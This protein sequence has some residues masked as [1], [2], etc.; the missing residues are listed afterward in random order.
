MRASE[1]NPNP[2]LSSLLFCVLCGSWT[3]ASRI[4]KSP[5]LTKKSS[6]GRFMTGRT[7]RSPT[8]VMVVFFP[9]FFKQYLTVGRL[10]SCSTF[11]LGMA[12]GIASFVLAIMAPW[13]GALGDRGQRSSA[14]CSQCSQCSASSR[15]A[16]CVRGDQGDWVRR[17]CCLRSPRSDS[18]AASSSTIRCWCD[19]A[20]R[21]RID[22]VSGVRLRDRLSRRR[23]A[24]AINVG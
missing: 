3:P 17:P 22:S 12:N 1:L 11:W 9:L 21:D 4:M 14:F 24:A 16:G 15:R 20:P 19:V 6:P 18:G 23:L 7:R 10:R 13:L 5:L 2:D 8:T